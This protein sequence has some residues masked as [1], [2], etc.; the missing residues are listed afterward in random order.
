ME[1]GSTRTLQRPK[2]TLSDC[3]ACS[4]CVTTAESVLVEA[5]S[6]A[7]FVR[8]MR[9]E[10]RPNMKVV[11]SVAPQI[12]ASLAA[13]QNL[14]MTSVYYRLHTLFTQHFGV[15]YF[16]DIS[17]ARDIA[18]LESSHE[19]CEVFEKNAERLPLLASA[20]PGWIC[21]AEKN[22]SS[23]VLKHLSTV[24][25][26]QQIMGSIVK[27]KLFP[28][29]SPADIYHVTLMPC[30]DKKLE[31]SR[32]DFYNEVYR[33]HDVDLV[34]TT[35]EVPSLLAEAGISKFDS[36]E[37]TRV[38][39][40]WFNKIATIDGQDKVVGVSGA[41]GSFA[42]FLFKRAAQTLF[43][44][45]VGVVELKS[46]VRAKGV[47]EVKLMR[48]GKAVLHFATAYGFSSIANLVKQVKQGL[49]KYHYVEVMA[50]PSG[51]LNGGGQLKPDSTLISVPS[52]TSPDGDISYTTRV[53]TAKE[54]LSAVE[55]HFAADQH[56]ELDPEN[57]RLVQ[58]LYHDLQCSV[59][60]PAA[61]SM[62][63]TQYHAMQ[64][65][66]AKNPLKIQW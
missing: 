17:H 48:D 24:K 2:I 58:G 44:E 13:S 6:V 50:C 19:F 31:A 30:W 64:Q 23:D 8:I 26:P 46:T 35:I 62:F 21:Y 49:T 16:F 55:A 29:V 9:S 20:C 41:S 60:D 3:L 66:E 1:D 34:L 57:D 27:N 52:T 42:E 47:K 37:E 45:D 65:A 4:G 5:Q 61:K 39:K 12:L 14:T 10:K 15:D 51:C 25:S 18:L 59:G 28:N 40:P 63:H 56:V 33:A 7:E 43:H 36:L 54:L 32:Q 53:M 11:V 38:S 22:S